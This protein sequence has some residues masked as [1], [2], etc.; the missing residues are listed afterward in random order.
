[1]ADGAAVIEAE[2]TAEVGQDVVEAEDTLAAEEPEIVIAI[3]GEEPEPDPDAE[4]EAELGEAGKRALKAAREAAREAKREAREAKAR[5]AELEAKLTPPEPEIKKP[6]LEE[7]GWNEDAFAEK[8]AAYVLAENKRKAEQDAI[9]EQERLAKEAYDARLAR[10]HEER[11]KFGVDDDAQAKVIAKLNEA[12]QV[13]LMKYSSDP[14]KLVAGLA[15]SPK[16]LDELSGIKDIGA[17]IYRLPIAE[18]KITVT[19]KAPPPPESKIRGGTAPS[20]SVFS[21]GDLEKLRAKAEQTG[22]YTEYFKAKAAAK[23]AKA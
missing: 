7:C 23:S 20:A 5:A 3:E 10:Y 21:A 6:T 19:T 13:A 9:K 16:M 18:G 2:E 22:N 12:Q 8:M 1:M 14:T 11:I 15:R 4:V 17:F